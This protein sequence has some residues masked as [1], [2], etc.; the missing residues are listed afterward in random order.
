MQPLPRLI[1]IKH[2]SACAQVLDLRTAAADG[3]PVL[4]WLRLLG[5]RERP[6]PELELGLLLETE[7][8]VKKAEERGQEDA[9]SASQR[10][11]DERLDFDNYFLINLIQQSFP[12][13]CVRCW[14]FTWSVYI[15]LF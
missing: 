4:K 7:E 15:V 9:G 8:D 3:R 11:E 13:G 14:H 1:F 10:I 12:K 5:A 2:V 6:H